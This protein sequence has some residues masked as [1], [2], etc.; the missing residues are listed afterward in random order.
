MCATCSRI[1]RR[2]RRC[3]ARCAI[4]TFRFPSMSGAASA[5]GSSL[6]LDGQPFTPDPTEVGA[7]NRGAYLVNGPGHCAECHCPRN[8]SA[9]SSQASASPAGP[10]RKA[11]AGC[12][13]SRRPVSATIRRGTSSIFSKPATCRTAIWSVARWPRWSATRHSSRPRTRRDGGLHQ[14][15]AAGGRTET[16]VTAAGHR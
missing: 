11:R 2:C 3:R 9:G 7:W 8:C 15:T 6:F 12:P 14:V 1:S 10:I 16:S 5:A 4:T 13:I